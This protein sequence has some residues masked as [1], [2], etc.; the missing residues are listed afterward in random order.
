MVT[1]YQTHLRAGTDIY[2]YR[3]A[4]AAY[5]LLL[6]TLALYKAVTMWREAPRPTGMGLLKVFIGDQTVYFLA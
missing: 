1:K 3:A 6:M 2:T 5:G 4:P